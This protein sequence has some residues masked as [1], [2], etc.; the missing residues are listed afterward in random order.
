MRSDIPPGR[1]VDHLTKRK[2]EDKM[3]EADSK[4]VQSAK[5]RRE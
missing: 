4:N 3:V 5:I 2:Q 1:G